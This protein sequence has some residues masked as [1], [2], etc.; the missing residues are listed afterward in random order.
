MNTQGSGSNI[1]VSQEEKINEGEQI[2]IE[3]NK[4]SWFQKFFPC[5]HYQA[6]APYFDVKTVDIKARFIASLM[7]FNQNFIQEY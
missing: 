2:N 3:S 6:L 1:S 4:K 5:L 7:P